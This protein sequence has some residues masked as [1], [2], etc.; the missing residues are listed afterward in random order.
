MVTRKIKFYWQ[1]VRQALKTD[2]LNRVEF[3]TVPE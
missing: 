3:A 2:S 1:A